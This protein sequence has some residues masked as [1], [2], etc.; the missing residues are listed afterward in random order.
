M[1]LVGEARGAF[2]PGGATRGIL[3]GGLSWTMLTPRAGG[4]AG[5]SG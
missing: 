1:P 5:R 4:W 2:L 3:L